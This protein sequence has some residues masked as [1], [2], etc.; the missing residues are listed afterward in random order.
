MPY[1]VGA[2]FW[3]ERSVLLPSDYG[4]RGAVRRVCDSPDRPSYLSDV[5]RA[6]GIVR[7]PGGREARIREAVEDRQLA[8]ALYSEILS[9]GD[10]MIQANRTFLHQLDLYLHVAL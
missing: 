10:Q 1:I 2:F 8:T 7:L 6:Y 4:I 9:S 3:E 5:R